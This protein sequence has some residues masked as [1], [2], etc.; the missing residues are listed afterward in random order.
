MESEQ[1]AVRTPIQKRGKNTKKILLKAGLKLISE[2]GFYKINSKDIARTAGVSIGSFYSYYNDKK[3]LFLELVKEYKDHSTLIEDC[4]TSG[5]DE[6]CGLIPKEIIKS[7]ILDKIGFASKYPDGFHK[8]LHYLRFRE[9][10]VEVLYNQYRNN[11]IEYFNK[12]LQYLNPAL[13]QKDS[14]TSAKLV[15]NIYEAIIESIVEI[16]EDLE[17]ENL[18]NE[19][20][21]LL[22]S[23]LLHE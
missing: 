18:I 12:T 2:E 13:S 8:E 14:P 10:D 20:I 11:E 5:M 7:F 3:E 15:F 21:E 23:Y 1:S 16:E 9:K 17:K 4:G 6:D 22:C 19:Y